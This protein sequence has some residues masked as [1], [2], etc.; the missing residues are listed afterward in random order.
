MGQYCNA[1]DMSVTQPLVSVFLPTF[2]QRNY[3]A[4]AIESALSQDYESLEIIV[5]DDCSVD[6]TW[7]VVQEYASR[8]SE[9]MTA[10]QNPQ[11]IGIT[12]NFNK[13]LKRCNGKYVVFHAGDDIFFPTKVRSQVQAMESNSDCCLCYHDVEVFESET[14]EVIRY[15]NSGKQSGSPVSGNSAK[16]ARRLVTQGT[17]FMAAVGIMV[18]RSAIP[19]W[20]FDERIRIAS[21]WLMWIDVCAGTD[22]AV[23]FENKVLS[24]Y[25]RHPA[26]V[27]SSARGDAAD[28]LVTLAV[29]EARYP[30]LRRE[31]RKAR[32]YHYYGF[33]V[34]RILEGEFF[35]GR[36]DLLNGLRYSMYSWKWIGW[37]LYSF[38]R[39]YGYRKRAQLR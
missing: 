38:L 8:N 33:G 25:R 11:N 27:T 24:R 5:G 39:Q 14:G 22:G 35:A 18:K 21:D 1:N 36:R 29:V 13:I 31:V 15:W 9:R 37:W 7:R 17:G 6:G 4:E 10:F 20:G 32:G 23:V 2:N 19:S 16:V 30:W 12:A 3:V 34:Q 26:N 28:Q